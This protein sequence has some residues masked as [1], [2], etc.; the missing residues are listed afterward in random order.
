MNI[1]LVA[2]LPP[3]L[4]RGIYFYF[5]TITDVFM[6]YKALAP[7]SCVGVDLRIPAP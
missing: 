3:I 6:G 2:C 7:W 5:V 4:G 1:R